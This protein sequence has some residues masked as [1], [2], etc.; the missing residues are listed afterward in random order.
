MSTIPPFGDVDVQPDDGTT[1]SDGS[2][3]PYRPSQWGDT[4]LYS[5]TVP[6]SSTS[7]ATVLVFDAVLR[8]NQSQPVVPTEHPVQTGTNV[9]DHAI[10]KQAR[11]TLEIGMSDA[12]DEFSP[13][14]WGGG[15]TKSINAFQTL[16][17]L[18]NNITLLTLTTRLA[19]YTNMLI[20]DIQPHED[21]T[22]LNALKATVLFQQMF[23]TS[24]TTV[25]TSA[26]PE[27]TDSISNGAQSPSDSL[28]QSVTNNN[29]NTGASPDIPG[30]SALSSY[31]ISNSPDF[32]F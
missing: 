19:S 28:P 21:Y 16:T 12:M 17:S 32:S 8:S 27:T 25:N 1:S 3:G 14:M 24:V 23:L 26:R 13:G 30:V 10:V 9:S 6:A 15:S 2:S 18:K 4:A 31:P 7:D 22:T 29:V 5:I 20:V 11:V